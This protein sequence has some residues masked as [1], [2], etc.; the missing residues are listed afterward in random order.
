MASNY[1]R[2]CPDGTQQLFCWPIFPVSGQSIASNDPVVHSRDLNLEFGHTEET[3]NKLL[4]S[5]ST[6]YTVEPLVLIWLQFELLRRVLT[7]TVFY[8][9]VVCHPLFILSHYPLKKWVDFLPFGQ[10]FADENWI[11]HVLWW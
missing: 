10:G 1:R 8:N 4:L 11:H 7:T 9:I 6:K 5:S 3:H 2:H